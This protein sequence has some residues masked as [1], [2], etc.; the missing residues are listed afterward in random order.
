MNIAWEE[1]REQLPSFLASPNPDIYRSSNY[2]VL[3]F[4]TTNIDKGTPLNPDNRLVLTC[5]YTPK[6]GWKHSWEGEYGQA[7]LLADISDADFIV[8]H[9]GKFELGWLRRCGIDLSKV[10]IWDTMIADYVEG[11]NKWQLQHLSLASCL[12]RRGLPT[13]L[14][15]VSKMIKA[16]ICPSTIP[17]SWLLAYCT[18]DVRSTALL[19]QSQLQTCTQLPIVFTRCLATPVL[20]DMEFNGMQLDSESVM[21]LWAEKERELASLSQ[22]LEELTGGINM[23]SPKQVAEY[24]YETLAFQEV[25]NHRGEP[26]RTASGARSASSDTIDS[27]VPST[28]AQESF[29]AVYKKAKET[30]NELTKYLRKFRDCC[31]QVGGFL[32]GQFNQTNTQ[33]HRLSSTGLKYRT[34]FQNFPRS[35]KKIFKAREEGWL[36]GEA[37]G[38]QLEFRVAAHLGRDRQALADIV[39]GEDIHRNTASVLNSVEPDAVTPA[40]RQDAKADTFKPLYGGKSGSPAQQRYYRY[41]GERYSGVTSTQQRWIDEVLLNKKLTTEWGMTYFWPNTRMERSG[42]VT[43]ST[44]ICN[45]PVQAFATAEIIPI[46]LVYMWH[47]IRL[48]PV[49]MFLVNTVHDSVIAELPEEEVPYFHALAER[50][51][52]A[53]VYEYL[54]VV[55]DVE[56]TVPLATGVKTAPRWGA[57]KEETV[58]QMAI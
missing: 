22:Q 26:I 35:Y 58:Y 27:L 4:E 38:A 44:A 56:F 55:Y 10:L 12:T 52:L 19:F 1:L 57:T 11:G 3:D 24:L 43:N 7:E 53:E 8:A 5:W 54:R 47:Y 15:T 39:R 41:F 48:L 36:V 32:Q 42:Y 9:N 40:Q 33:T 25:R 31:E 17:R 18:Q 14:D 13:K 23:N 50:C 49:R 2:L 37:D 28:V 29:L 45:Y 30:S 21:S 46:T 16:G 6:S 34:Q 51:F 20:T